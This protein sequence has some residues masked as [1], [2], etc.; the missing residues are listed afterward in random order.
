MQAPDSARNLV[1]LSHGPRSR[2]RFQNR[3]PTCPGYS[4]RAICGE[5]G[6][7]KGPRGLSPDDLWSLRVHAADSSPKRRNL[8]GSLD[9]E[10]LSP[11]GNERSNCTDAVVSAH[12]AWGVATLGAALR[13]GAGS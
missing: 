2:G 8:D 3:S 11:D 7:D 1:V 4:G 6:I 9:A 10:V 12:G 5:T 13:T